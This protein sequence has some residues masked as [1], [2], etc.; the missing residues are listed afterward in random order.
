[1]ADSVLSGMAKSMGNR[2]QK[3]KDEEEANA[4][5]KKPAFK[6]QQAKKADVVEMVVEDKDAEIDAEAKAA[7]GKKKT[8]PAASD[9]KKTAKK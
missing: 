9:K 7:K 5:S 4:A 3:D 1:M 8:A 6:Q 2:T